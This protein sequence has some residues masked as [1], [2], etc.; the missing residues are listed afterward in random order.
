MA[1]RASDPLRV[2]DEFW[3]RDDV[4]GALA[5]RD[6]GALFQLVRRH[7]C[8]S[9]TQL[10]IAAGLEQGYVSRIM[11]G[12]KVMVID[13]LE[14]IADGFGMPST[15]RVLL[16]LAPGGHAS[17]GV[18]PPAAVHGT[19][20]DGVA[21]AVELW[22]GDVERREVLRYGA[23]TAAGFTLPA[24]RWFTGEGQVDLAKTGQRA[25]G[26]PDV[27]MIRE[28]TGT[29]RQL[30]NQYGGGRLRQTLVRYL[31]NEVT[32]LL[33]DGRFDHATGRALLSASAEATQLA[34]WMA[35]DDGEHALGQRYLIQALDLA[36]AADD[37]PLGA[38]ILAAM[39]HQAVYLGDSAVAVELARASGRTAD[40][41]GVP[42]VV[43]EALVM[44]AHAH[45]RLGDAATCAA[46][47]S[48]AEVALDQADRSRDPQRISYFDEAYLAA[49]FGHCFRELKQ[50]KQ[51]ER[52]AVQSLKMDS[53]YVRGRAFNLLLLATACAQ[54]G[55]AARACAIGD[56]A[57]EL[58]TRLHSA[59]AHGYLRELQ[60]SLAPYGK[61]PLVRQ[62]NTRVSALL[63]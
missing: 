13:V 31:D 14:R 11:A 35:Y 8:A 37:K 4:R 18:E 9:Q 42:V 32:P 63:R 16:G 52:F 36:K 28:M 38:E 2:P 56:K 51:A 53:R 44:Q 43:A 25:V 33:R 47:L 34:G 1:H 62:F 20:Q 30:D 40:H 41:A 21:A 6:I 3:A 55:D 15:P 61:A 27:D 59:R 58:T 29:F 49:R 12:R 54:V 60:N 26:Q 57:L 7:T 5:E 45:A 10:G 46:L 48:R 23:F 24:L 39:S 17:A 22:R 50:G 19:W